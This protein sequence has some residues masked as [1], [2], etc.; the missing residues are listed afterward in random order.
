M[1]SQ[2]KAVLQA[3]SN[4]VFVKSSFAMELNAEHGG[5]SPLPSKGVSKP[6][7]SSC[8]SVIRPYLLVVIG[9]AF[10][11]GA[12]IGYYGRGYTVPSSCSYNDTLEQNHAVDVSVCDYLKQ[13][14]SQCVQTI[15]KIDYLINQSRQSQALNHQLKDD[16]RLE[17]DTALGKDESQISHH[18]RRPPVEAWDM[19]DG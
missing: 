9:A 10:I 11:I 17:V 2:Q 5:Y 14:L 13:N 16:I 6:S 3:I 12:C 4:F 7:M 1:D 18:R 15:H 19:T 8:W